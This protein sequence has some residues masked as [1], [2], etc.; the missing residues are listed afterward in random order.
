M[1]FH[2]L[3]QDVVVLRIALAGFGLAMVLASPVISAGGSRYALILEAPW[4]E[5]R[6]LEV[7]RNAGGVLMRSGWHN[8]VFYFPEGAVVPAW[9]QETASVPV[10][11]ASQMCGT[12]R[13]MEFR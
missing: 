11:A 7:G 10:K 9:T 12:E 4:S 2:G 3:K 6:A 5:G 1:R 8:A 13:G